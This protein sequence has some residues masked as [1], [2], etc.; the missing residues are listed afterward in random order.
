MI[1]K[2]CRPERPKSEDR[3]DSTSLPALRVDSEEIGG[4]KYGEIV[5]DELR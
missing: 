5:D 4:R 3:P 2:E 1:R